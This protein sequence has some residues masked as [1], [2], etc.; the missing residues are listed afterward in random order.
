MPL[1]PLL[2]PTSDAV[3]S[4]LCLMACPSSRAIFSGAGC[5]SSGAAVAAGRGPIADSCS[6]CYSDRPKHKQVQVQLGGNRLWRVRGG[7]YTAV[8]AFG[9]NDI[10][11]SSAAGDGSREVQISS[12]CP[13]AS[14]T[15]PTAEKGTS[16]AG[17][18]PIANCEAVEKI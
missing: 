3:E 9:M 15:R 12:Q 11:K 2:R 7:V 6:C 10:V 17:P 16:R 18:R 1:Q 13:C 4:S 14:T 5:C 8:A